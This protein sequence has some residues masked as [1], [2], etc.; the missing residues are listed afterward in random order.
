MCNRTRYQDEA[1]CTL[2]T[3][4]KKMFYCAF[5]PAMADMEAPREDQAFDAADPVPSWPINVKP[6]NYEKISPRK[7]SLQA[8]PDPPRRSGEK[9]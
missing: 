1:V 5:Q 9:H 8:H 2:F 7:Y 4:V 3:E 6:S